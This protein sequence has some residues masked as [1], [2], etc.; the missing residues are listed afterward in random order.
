MT[1]S[2]WRAT[3]A[4]PKLGEECNRLIAEDNAK[5]EGIQA[6]KAAG[7]YVSPTQEQVQE[8]IQKQR[9]GN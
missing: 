9:T 4:D 1:E 6:E 8:R 2:V 7:T 3:G 5:K